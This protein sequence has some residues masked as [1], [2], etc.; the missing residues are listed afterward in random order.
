M[1]LKFIIIVV[2]IITVIVIG[3]N[4]INNTILFEDSVDEEEINLE[5]DNGLTPEY[6][7][8]YL[9]ENNFNI[10]PVSSKENYDVYA[11]K[12]YVGD[13]DVTV[14]VD[15]YYD[16]ERDKV[17]LIKSTID[18]S[19]YEDYDNP[20][21]VEQMVTEITKEYLEALISFPYNSSEP[22]RARDWLETHVASAYNDSNEM[23]VDIGLAT[24]H[25][26][27]S[28]LVRVMEMD[29]EVDKLQED[30]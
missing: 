18:G 30:L 8:D 25:L 4:V 2:G 21:V 28:S 19:Y 16:R 5:A 12:R 22:E 15:V 24:I 11:A 23:S 7:M 14:Q 10:S 20:Q 6:L 27:G 17:L 1:N 3:L 13:I 29:F 26:S 9:S